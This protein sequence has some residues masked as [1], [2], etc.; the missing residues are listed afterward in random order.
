MRRVGHASTCQAV[1]N[2]LRWL[3]TPFPP[4]G[5][6]ICLIE[7]AYAQAPSAALVR[8]VAAL[9]IHSLTTPV[10]RC[11]TPARLP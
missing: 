8:A 6:E 11:A 1:A 3:F 9:V 4:V 10:H 7:G 2:A 5:A